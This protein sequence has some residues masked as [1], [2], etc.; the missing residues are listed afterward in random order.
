MAYVLHNGLL[1]ND[2]EL[3][4]P[5]L[6]DIEVQVLAWLKELLISERHADVRHSH[7]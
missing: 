3:Y 4:D 7:I 1:I 5:E 6:A 2:R